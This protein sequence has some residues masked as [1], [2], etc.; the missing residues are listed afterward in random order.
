LSEFETGIGQSSI[1]NVADGTGWP[2]RETDFSLI[3][4]GYR[5]HPGQDARLSGLIRG[6]LVVMPV[7]DAG[8]HAV[9]R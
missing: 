2:I 8:I 1:V 5:L 9:P 7:L 3:E 6:P 4:C